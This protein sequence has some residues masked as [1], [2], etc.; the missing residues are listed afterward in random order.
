MYGGESKSCGLGATGLSLL[1]MAASLLELYESINPRVY[2]GTFK[3]GRKKCAST[4]YEPSETFNLSLEQLGRLRPSEGKGI[5]LSSQ[6]HPRSL[7]LEVWKV[8]GLS[9]PL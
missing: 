2:T 3:F 5:D 4:E 6:P 8:W 1:L 9:L 7:A